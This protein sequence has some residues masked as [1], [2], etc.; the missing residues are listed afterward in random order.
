MAE[1]DGREE[2]TGHLIQTSYQKVLV[3]HPR[4]VCQSPVNTKKKSQNNAAQVN[5]RVNSSE[6]GS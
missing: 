6:S 2:N 5:S 1:G 3:M 4:S